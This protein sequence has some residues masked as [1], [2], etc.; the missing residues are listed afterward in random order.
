MANEIPISSIDQLQEELDK[1]VRHAYTDVADLLANQSEQKIGN[2]IR[3]TNASADPNVVTGT[4]YYEYTGAETADLGDYF[5]VSAPDSSAIQEGDGITLDGTIVKI[6]DVDL[7]AS[8]QISNP[9]ADGVASDGVKWF[10]NPTGEGKMQAFFR[11]GTGGER[12][13]ADMTVG[14]DVTNAIAQM[15]AFSN[16]SGDTY[17]MGIRARNGFIELGDFFGGWS[18]FGLKYLSDYAG[19]DWENDELL[20]PHQRR[21]IDLISANAPTPDLTELNTWYVNTNGNDTTGDGSSGKPFKT[22]AKAIT[23]ASTLDRIY[24][25]YGIH[26]ITNLVIDKYL[27]IELNYRASISGSVEFDTTSG[28]IEVAFIGKGYNVLSLSITVSGANNLD[29]DVES[30]SFNINSLTGLIHS[31]KIKDSL[32]STGGSVALALTGNAD[33]QDVFFNV[34]NNFSAV[35]VKCYNCYI[36]SEGN[37]DGSSEVRL[38]NTYLDSTGVITTPVL[39]RFN[40]TIVNATI[41]AGIEETNNQF[42]DAP[43]DGN[44]YARKDAG[45]EVINEFDVN[46]TAP[47]DA[48]SDGSNITLLTQ[49]KY[50]SVFNGPDISAT[51]QV[52]DVF[53][54]GVNASN[55]SIEGASITW[56]F[57]VTDGT[58]D[59]ILY[60]NSSVEPVTF[61]DNPNWND[62]SKQLSGVGQGNYKIEGK[63]ISGTWNFEIFKLEGS[64]TEAPIDGNQYARKDGGWEQVET[65]GPAI[66]NRY[67]DIT[68]LLA[69]QGNQTDGGIQR[70]ADASADSTVDSGGAWYEYLGTTVGDLTDYRKL[71]EDE[72]VEGGSELE[73]IQTLSV[74]NA[75]NTAALALDADINVVKVTLDAAL[76]ADWAPSGITGWVEGRTYTFHIIKASDNGVDM[77]T[78]R[79]VPNVGYDDDID[80]FAALIDIDTT[81]K[82]AMIQATGFKSTFGQFGRLIITDSN[83]VE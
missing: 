66:E 15:W 17:M 54:V 32:A 23:E 80:P 40:S 48:D 5:L 6:G 10:L 82:R 19:I 53:I 58:I 61:L 14:A 9:E 47:I 75:N 57:E 44:Q 69:Q 13:V 72:S 38:V 83:Y 60:F 68:T 2:L 11:N 35:A 42:I 71:S 21:V 77:S 27:N 28:A 56:Y 25:Q 8:I 51:A 39:F 29:I 43:S 26:S 30:C 3:V 50:L 34:E 16:V 20:V 67:A 24:I 63:L 73:V 41:I 46:Q 65:S 64:V 70:V 1:I 49:Q 45:W 37:F 52:V 55:L 81:Q 33:L 31:L 36:D 18:V 78:A 79:A 7:Q 59:K 74:T 22:L 62:V 76:T 12:K 4:A